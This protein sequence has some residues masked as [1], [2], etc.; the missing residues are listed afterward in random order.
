MADASPA[1]V[2]P[3]SLQRRVQSWW[4]KPSEMRARAMRSRLQA[5]SGSLFR[6]GLS[7]TSAIYG[8]YQP[9]SYFLAGQHR[10]FDELFR[11]FASHNRLNN[12]GDIPRLWA[13]IL[14]CK[15]ILEE[16]I[17]GD[18]AEL[19]VWR[20]NTAAVLASYADAPG[21]SVYLFDTYEGFDGED[22]HGIDADKTMAFA[23]TS[24]DVVR[25]VVGESRTN[26]IYVKGRFP[27]SIAAAH[28]ER[29]YALVSIDCD[30][31]EPMKAALEFFYPRMPRGGMLLL[32]DYSSLQWNGAKQAIDEFCRQSGEFI[33]LMPDKS[34]SAFVRKTA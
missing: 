7:K 23:N 3:L 2:G 25:G 6:M 16:K 29:Q 20:G 34:G 10:E 8:A 14:N 15:Q 33:V 30:L 19:G 27:G 18:F 17:P 21:R 32:H 1:P 13:L 11:R 5:L 28:R 12:G 26:C 9:D 24:V 4:R 31:Y 22:L